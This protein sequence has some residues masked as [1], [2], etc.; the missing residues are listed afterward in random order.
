M[1]SPNTIKPSYIAA[2]KEEMG[3]PVR[4]AHNR[5]GNERKVQPPKRLKPIIKQAILDLTLTK[6][7]PTYK[8][9]QRRAFEIQKNTTEQSHVLETKGIFSG[10]RK[11][12]MEFIN[13][14][15]IYYNP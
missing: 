2:I 11:E 3:L 5:I 13:D 8:E 14:K 12:V 1:K 15:E 6:K 9:I 7:K 10:N 4:Q